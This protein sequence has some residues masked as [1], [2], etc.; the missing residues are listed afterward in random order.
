MTFVV[1]VHPTKKGSDNFPQ[2]LHKLTASS[3]SHQPICDIHEVACATHK[4]ACMEVRM[5]DKATGTYAVG[6]MAHSAAG[7]SK[8]LHSCAAST[9]LPVAQGFATL[10]ARHKLI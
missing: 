3:H 8:G 10:Q 6:V 9:A 1:K 4:V 7:Y 5:H 2:F